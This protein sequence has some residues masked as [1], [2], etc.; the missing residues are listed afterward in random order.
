MF[1]DQTMPS[2]YMH[3]HGLDHF[4]PENLLLPSQ[5]RGI[6]WNKSNE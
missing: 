5:A 3:A 4:F 2:S 1:K 6:L